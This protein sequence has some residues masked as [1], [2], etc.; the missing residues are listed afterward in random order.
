MLC[1][2]MCLLLLFLVGKLNSILLE[3]CTILARTGLAVLWLELQEP[4]NRG[5]C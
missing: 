2:Q 5:K 1:Y 4:R 3:N